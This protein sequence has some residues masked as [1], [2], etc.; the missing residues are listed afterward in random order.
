MAK[1]LSKLLKPL[2]DDAK[3]VCQGTKQLTD[4]LRN[5][6]LDKRQPFKIIT[7][8]IVAYYPNIPEDHMI[9]IMNLIWTRYYCQD[10]TKEDRESG[11]Y[12]T[13]E[14][15]NKILIA[16]MTSLIIEGPD[17]QTYRQIKGLAMGVA[18]SPDIANLYGNW[19]ERDWIH[20]AQCV[21]FYHRYI[22]DIFAIVYIDDWDPEYL[23][24][25]DARSYMSETICF[26]GCTID[27]EPPT[28]A[29]AFL[30]LWIYID[31]DR[32]LQ[33]KPYCKAGNH[34]ER[35]PWESAH[36]TDIKRGTFIG[37]LSR[38]ATLSSKLEHYLAAV[39]DLSNLYVQRGYPAKVISHWKK[40][41]IRKRWEVKDLPK[42]DCEDHVIMLK[43]VFNDAW[44]SFNIHELEH[45]MIQPILQYMAEWRAREP[46][47]YLS[48]DE[49]DN[50]IPMDSL[51]GNHVDVF[52]E[53]FA[54]R[55]L[56]GAS[57]D[58]IIEA[59]SDRT[60]PLLKRLV[61]VQALD[62]ELST[63]EMNLLN[64]EY[65]ILGNR[66]FLLSR[67]RT[68]NV[69]DLVTRWRRSQVRA[70]FDWSDD[71]V[72][73]IMLQAE[74]DRDFFFFVLEE[75]HKD[76]NEA[77]T[78][79]AEVED[80]QLCA[81]GG[82]IGRDALDFRGLRQLTLSQAWSRSSTQQMDTSEWWQ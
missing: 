30:D 67:K 14:L 74:R 19:F 47:S 78:H 3:Y 69:G 2:I 52:V 51:L 6:K 27:W 81:E 77:Y 45:V 48:P 13:L 40:Q 56:G 36:P 20:Q 8:D 68:A 58:V 28:D 22:D 31:G 42:T 43:T 65:W 9:D 38:L 66:Q 24:E 41:Y 26:D 4:Q 70:S 17:G 62:G 33:W 32:T 50:V 35:I 76:K 80:D 5:V 64:Y 54:G 18:C 37:E 75:I 29:L 60:A 49:V 34:R 72:S 71:P 46:L 82:L 39:R 44:N 15:F 16:A 7:G 61:T 55:T 23:G 21:A 79:A 73:V 63:S 1:Y 10:L 53:E 25:R 12:P 57:A 11:A 59:L